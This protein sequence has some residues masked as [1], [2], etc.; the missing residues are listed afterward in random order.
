MLTR[1]KKGGPTVIL[2][3]RTSSDRIGKRVP[4]R[5]E[6]ATPTSRRLLKR[7]AASRLSIDSSCTS[8][9]S[10]GQR[11]YSRVKASTPLIAR[12]ARKKY[13]TL[14]WVK[15]CTLAITPERVMKVPKMLRRKVPMM[16]PRFQRLSIPRFSWIMTE[17][18]NAVMVSQGSRLAFSTGSQA[19]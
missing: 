19:Q 4:Q 9:L 17:W 12:K 8:A 1:L 16:S 13:P 3:P 11:V 6:K 10:E 15:L 2:L 5:T 14:D 18:R 7:N